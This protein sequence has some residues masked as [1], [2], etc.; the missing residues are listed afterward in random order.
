[1][2]RGDTTRYA[3]WTMDVA[4]AARPVCGI[5]FRRS[6]SR[7]RHLDSV[8]MRYVVENSATRQP[9]ILIVEDE[10]LLRMNPAEM[11]ADTRF[12]PAEPGNPAN[13]T[14][15]PEPPPYL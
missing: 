11:T 7:P 9:V 5:P 14:A 6:E 8:G 4:R 10:F 12:A 1:M 15:V 3:G 2:T 13:A